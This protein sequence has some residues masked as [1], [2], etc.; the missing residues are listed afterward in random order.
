MEQLPILVSKVDSFDGQTKAL[1]LPDADTILE[2]I[3]IEKLQANLSNVCMG[4]TRALSDIKEVGNF[5]LKEVSI[6]VEVTASG[7][8]NLIGTATLGGKGAIT[9]KFVE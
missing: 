4:L 5:R 8:V 3:P 1:F 9:L 7:G 2:H 6:Q